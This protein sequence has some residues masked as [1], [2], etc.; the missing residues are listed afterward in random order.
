MLHDHHSGALP[1][2]LHK[3]WVL[4]VPSR[5]PALKTH[6][7]QSWILTANNIRKLDALSSCIHCISQE[8]SMI[9][10][11]FWRL[12]KPR[13]VISNLRPGRRSHWD[14][15]LA[16]APDGRSDGF[17]TQ[18]GESKN[19]KNPRS[20]RKFWSGGAILGCEETSTALLRCIG[21]TSQKSLN[22]KYVA[23]QLKVFPRITKYISTTK[24]YI[25]NSGWFAMRPSR[26]DWDALVAPR[27]QVKNL[28]WCHS[29]HCAY[30]CP[31]KNKLDISWL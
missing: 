12:E 19:E 8:C 20:R 24:M 11:S 10:G 14:A 13:S 31:T 5:C 9:D 23:F 25:S 21:C 7:T 2:C 26:V 27:I 18:A 16:T 1:G 6:Q 30:H 3:K 28:F 4:K 22:G 17:W 15:S 29:R